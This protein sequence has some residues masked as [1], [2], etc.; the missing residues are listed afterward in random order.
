MPSK[1]KSASSKVSRDAAEEAVRTLLRWAGDDPARE[2][3]LD[4]PKRVVNAYADWFSGYAIDPAEYLRRF[5]PDLDRHHAGMRRGAEQQPVAIKLRCDFLITRHR[6]RLCT[7]PAR[8]LK[9]G[10][11]LT[12]RAGVGRQETLVQRHR[13]LAV[14][15]EALCLP[16]REQELAAP[17]D[18]VPGFQIGDGARVVARAEAFEPALVERGGLGSHRPLDVGGGGGPGRG[19]CRR[20]GGRRRGNGRRGRWGCRRGHGTGAAPGERG[21]RRQRQ[22]GQERGG[23]A[24]HYYG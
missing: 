15:G 4:T 13:A 3:L 21:A 8:L 5:R 18:R 10:R 17:I 24:S 9:S 19:R 22:R 2:G 14:A 23:G 20:G 11:S 7:R 6:L 1:K 12:H 16:L